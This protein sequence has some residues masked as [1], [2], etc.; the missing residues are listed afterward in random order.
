MQLKENFSLS[1][2]NHIFGTGGIVY[3]KKSNCICQVN[4]NASACAYYESQKI[5]LITKKEKWHIKE[6]IFQSQVG[7]L[8]SISGDF[9]TK[10]Q[11]IIEGENHLKLNLFSKY[12]TFA[13]YL[14]GKGGI[15]QVKIIYTE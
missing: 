2:C 5:R 10:E 15:S 1:T 3:D 9:G 11:A 6:I 4:K 13:I 8:I 12:Y 14:E 7:G